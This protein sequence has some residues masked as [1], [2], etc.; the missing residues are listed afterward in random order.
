M[1]YVSYQEGMLQQTQEMLGIF[2]HNGPIEHA[3]KYPARSFV[4]DRD[5]TKPQNCR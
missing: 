1:G 5:F 3:P 4:E 2:T